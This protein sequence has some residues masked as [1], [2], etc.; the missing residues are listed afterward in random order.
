MISGRTDA[1]FAKRV[2]YSCTY[3]SSRGSE[4]H[5]L[6]VIMCESIGLVV[7][8][9][10]IH[11]EREHTERE[12]YIIYIYTHQAGE[13]RSQYT[14]VTLS[15]ECVPIDRENRGADIAMLYKELLYSLR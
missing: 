10:P 15:F 12:K 2:D 7:G 8:M 6:R 9:L 13:K 1:K 4:H 14:S 11:V 3:F 5:K